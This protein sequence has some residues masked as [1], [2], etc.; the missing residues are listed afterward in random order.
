MNI[1]I[2]SSLAFCSLVQ[3]CESL[4]DCSQELGCLKSVVDV[5][6]RFHCGI[7]K[8]ATTSANGES[9]FTYSPN[10]I[11]N[12]EILAVYYN[13]LRENS[14]FPNLKVPR[15]SANGVG[16]ETFLDSDYCCDPTDK[17]RCKV[18]FIFR[19]SLFYNFYPPTLFRLAFPIVPLTFQRMEGTFNRTGVHRVCWA[20]M[21][22]CATLK[23]EA[24]SHIVEEFSHEVSTVLITHLQD[25]QE[26][27]YHCNICTEFRYCRS[28]YFCQ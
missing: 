28:G 7:Q 11:R 15:P 20:K 2:V 17:D 16:N 5:R 6:Q 10:D 4:A 18:Y 14:T 21:L 12:Y 9:V 25:I 24:I 27:C 3:L 19:L 1:I 23:N 8:A 13:T 22:F 26:L